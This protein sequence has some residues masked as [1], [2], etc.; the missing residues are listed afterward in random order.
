MS[1]FRMLPYLLSI[2]NTLSNRE[3]SYQSKAW[4]FGNGVHNY[5]MIDEIY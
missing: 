4:S 3:V 5:Y 2:D 1:A